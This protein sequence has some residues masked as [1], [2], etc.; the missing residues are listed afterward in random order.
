MEL[1][2][3]EHWSGFPFP[4][5]LPNPGMEPRSLALQADFFT[6][7]ATREA[8]EYWS[9]CPIPFPGDLPYPGIELGCPA[10]QADSLPAELPGK[11]SDAFYDNHKAELV[12][13]GIS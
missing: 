8:Q 4:R 7:R 5:Y 6:S 13:I 10:L 12:G 2:R 9:G 1:S 11:P 3:P